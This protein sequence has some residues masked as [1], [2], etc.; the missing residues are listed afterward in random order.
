MSPEIISELYEAEQMCATGKDPLDEK[1]KTT[2]KA[3]VYRK[4]VMFISYVFSTRPNYLYSL[5]PPYFQEKGE[6]Q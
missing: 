4:K 1:K 2:S 3:V 6:E 5:L